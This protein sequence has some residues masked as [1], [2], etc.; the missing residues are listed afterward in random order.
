MLYAIVNV[1]DTST[2]GLEIYTTKEE[3]VKRVHGD[4]ELVEIP[5]EKYNEELPVMQKYEFT[6]VVGGE[7]CHNGGEYWF[8][9]EL[10]PT[11]YEGFF[12]VITGTSCDFDNCGTGYEGIS[13]FTAEDI[14]RMREESDRIE[15]QGFLY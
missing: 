12:K 9:T 7:K 5:E 2:M 13:F 4:I 10:L 6:D 1:N 15:A 11:P 3:A 8:Y 14:K